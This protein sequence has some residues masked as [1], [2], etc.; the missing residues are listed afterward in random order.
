MWKRCLEKAKGLFK[1]AK[2][3]QPMTI[4]KLYFEAQTDRYFLILK[5]AGKSKQE[6]SVFLTIGSVFDENIL[7][8]LFI[9][10]DSVKKILDQLGFKIKKI[11][12][13]KKVNS[14]NS[15]ECILKSL[16]FSKTIKISTIEA[17]RLAV[18]SNIK[19]EVLPDMLKADRLDLS[20]EA[21]SGKNINGVFA[22]KFIERDL[23]NNNEVVM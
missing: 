2:K 11:R 23:Y 15:A 17:I 3:W 13:L 16:I 4:D 14:S 9:K 8:S 12:I 22:P 21:N 6:E 18:E 10:N 19:V 5:A 7:S 20:E 1:K